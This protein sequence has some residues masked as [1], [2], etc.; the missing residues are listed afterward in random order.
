MIGQLAARTGIAPLALREC[1]IADDALFQA[2]AR[3][4]GDWTPELELAA[5]QLEVA[6]E[7]LRVVLA[8]GGVKRLPPPLSIPRRRELKRHA[9]PR[10]SIADLARM[11]GQ[12]IEQVTP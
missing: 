12:S 7:T 4:A 11:T 1:A 10:V 8:L 3:A 5:T 9:A 2:V 6:H